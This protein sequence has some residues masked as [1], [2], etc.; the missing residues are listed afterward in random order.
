MTLFNG[1][2]D[3]KTQLTNIPFS[4]CFDLQISHDHWNWY[5]Q[6]YAV[7][8]ADH[9]AKLER[10]QSNGLYGNSSVNSFAMACKVA[11]LTL[12]VTQTHICSGE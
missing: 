5:E 6:A 3:A 7:Q 1:W 2:P 4:R 11:D 9:H 12:I 10:S 8:E